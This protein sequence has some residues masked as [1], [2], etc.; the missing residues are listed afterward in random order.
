MEGAG[1]KAILDR[2]KED[3]HLSTGEGVDEEVCGNVMTLRELML[4]TEQLVLEKQLWV[5]TGFQMQ[6]LGRERTLPQP[7]CNTG[8]ILEL[9]GNL[10]KSMLCPCVTL[11]CKL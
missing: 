1:P 7:E 3:W 6:Y 9:Y 10:C 5:L 11:L 8:R 4:M 2:L